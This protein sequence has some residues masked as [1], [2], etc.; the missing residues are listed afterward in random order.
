MKKKILWALAAVMVL[1][2]VAGVVVYANINRILKNVVETQATSQL[3]VKTTLNSADLSI[4]GGKLGLNQLEIA[5]PQG[6]TAEHM[7]TLGDAK[8]AVEYGQLRSDP[9]H[10]K[11]II[12]K[13]P[14]LVIEQKDMKLNFQ[15]LMDQK[16]KGA[17]QPAPSGS[18]STPSPDTSSP[19]PAESKP[20]RLIIDDIELEGA[21]VVLRAGLPGLSKDLVVQI[22]SLSIKNIGSGD[23]SE[24]G[25]AVKDVVMQVVTAMA[26]KSIDVAG[27]KGQL[28]QMLAAGVQDMAKQLTG[29]F[30]KQLKQIVP[31]QVLQSLPKGVVPDVGK[32]LDDLTKGL[33]GDKKK[34]K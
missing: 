17:D 11:Q 22:P 23:G 16:P 31:D 27:L 25:A 32:S 13:K 20:L 26:S 33:G 2:I 21:E 1:V 28:Q 9:V 30:N 24:N 6:Y 4:F 3:N 19:K 14:R 29:E 12:L 10:I 7:F 5:S 8:V 15:A 34:D 18:P